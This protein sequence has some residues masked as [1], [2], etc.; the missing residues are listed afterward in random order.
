MNI[1][2]FHFRFII[3]KQVS[4]LSNEL[5]RYRSHD[6][7]GKGTKWKRNCHATAVLLIHDAE[8]ADDII[9]LP[10]TSEPPVTLS[11]PAPSGVEKVNENLSDM[12]SLLDSSSEDDVEN[13]SVSGYQASKS[14]S[15]RTNLFNYTKYGTRSKIGEDEIHIECEKPS[16]FSTYY[17]CKAARAE[18]CNYAT[19][20]IFIGPEA[21]VSEISKFSS[22]GSLDCHSDTEILKTFRGS[23]ITAGGVTI[24]Q[25]ILATFDPSNLKCAVCPNAH[26]ILTKDRRTPLPTL[27]LADQNFVSTL[28]SGKSCI[29]ID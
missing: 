4:N 17:Q 3:S 14:S 19:V 23:R 20:D 7:N 18:L 21:G 15:N 8:D 12:L 13:G 6:T 26:Y 29:A 16:M 5:F 9:M 22:I 1:N 2:H 28:S 11:P 27:I 24:N 10:Q 25:N